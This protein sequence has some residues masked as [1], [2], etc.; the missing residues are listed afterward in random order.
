MA[1]VNVSRGAVDTGRRSG[2][3][4]ALLRQLA[5]GLSTYRLYPGEL[6]Q[7]AFRTAAERVMDAADAAV[8]AGTVE[9]TV[10][11]GRFHVD[12]DAVVSERVNRL[13]DACFTRRVEYLRIERRPTLDELDA[14]FDALSRDPDEVAEAGGI[15]NLL[16]ARAVTAI[17]ASAGAPAP[18][19]GDDDATPDED[20]MSTLRLLPDDNA[21]A[22]YDRLRT[23]GE[24]LDEITSARSSFF[25]NAAALVTGL[26]AHE[27][28]AFD[29]LVV[30]RVTT[31]AFAERYAG[32][33]TDPQVARL[34]ARAARHRQAEP[35][36]LAIDFVRRT[37]RQQALVAVVRDL[38]TGTRAPATHDDGP[39]PAGGGLHEGFPA[40]AEDGRR[41]ALVALG[42]YLRADVAP[43]QLQRVVTAVTKQLRAYVGK[44]ETGHVRDLLGVLDDARADLPGDVGLLLRA[45][46]QQA[47]TPALV[48]GVVGRTP[49][50]RRTMDPLRPFGPAAIDALVAAVARNKGRS[51]SKLLAAITA[52]V[53]DRPKDLERHLDHDAWHVVRDLATVLRRVGGAATVPQLERLAGHEHEAV[54]REALRGLTS[55][56]TSESA[57]AIA[58]AI[59]SLRTPAEQEEG[60]EALA[61]SNAPQAPDLL[62]ALAARRGRPRLS[63]R[64]RRTARRAARRWEAA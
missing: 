1:I 57:H 33:L 29:D 51:D 20:A 5:V 44:G 50:P 55:L 10:Q 26:D 59:P 16:E 14:F 41:L 38:V 61:A 63:W 58:R 27:H 11:A 9:A 32:H 64:L 45:P 23:A 15:G 54:R 17:V 40:D 22:V 36:E 53:H 56:P 21:T 48:A 47:L 28:D 46:R 2:T 18:T 34:I 39:T 6:T 24:A 7:P 49:D 35:I 13:A 19:T 25:R 4:E 42:D 31:D 3:V 43:E 12:E 30:D 60:I 37:G 8:A 52:V 62:R